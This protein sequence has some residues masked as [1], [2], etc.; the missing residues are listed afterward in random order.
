MKNILFYMSLSHDYP[1][2]FTTVF[3]DVFSD[4]TILAENISD[5]LVE[6]TRFF[7]ENEK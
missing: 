6:G 5:A 3:T 1:S 2:L 7:Y 4:D